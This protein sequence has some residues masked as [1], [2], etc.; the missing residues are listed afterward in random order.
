MKNEYHIHSEN[1]LPG[2]IKELEMVIEEY[3]VVLLDGVMAA[4]KTTLVGAYCRYKKVEDAT[5]SPTFGLVNEYRT[6]EQDSIFHF[7]LYRVEDEEELYDIGF[8]EYLDSGAVCFIEWPGIA[9]N[10]L[11]V[12]HILLNLQVVPTGERVIKLTCID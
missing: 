9:E 3:K 1:D 2:L 7:D 12:K 11:P 6:P 8:E 5:S 4:G 10:F